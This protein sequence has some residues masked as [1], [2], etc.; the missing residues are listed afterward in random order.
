[1]LPA[2]LR[3]GSLASHSAIAACMLLA[4]ALAERRDPELLGI[5]LQVVEFGRGASIHLVLSARKARRAPIPSGEDSPSR[6]EGDRTAM[7]L[8]GFPR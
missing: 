8:P 5:G 7:A 2:P 1:V 3:G 4:L 6:R